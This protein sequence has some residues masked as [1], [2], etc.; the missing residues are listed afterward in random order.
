MRDGGGRNVEFLAGKSIFM[1]DDVAAHNNVMVAYSLFYLWVAFVFA[2]PVALLLARPNMKNRRGRG[3]AYYVVATALWLLVFYHLF[4]LAIGEWPFGATIAAAIL[5]V[6]P[7]GLSWLVS[8][9]LGQN[10]TTT[11]EGS[12]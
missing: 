9:G 4:P 10:K 8:A 5:C 11:I 1:G 12:R 7:W 2:A 3:V 6:S